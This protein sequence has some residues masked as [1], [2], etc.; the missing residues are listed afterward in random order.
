VNNT[1]SA[2]VGPELQRFRKAD[3]KQCA[4]CCIVESWGHVPSSSRDSNTRCNDAWRD[5]GYLFT[6]NFRLNFEEKRV[7]PN[8]TLGLNSSKA[9]ILTGKFSFF[10]SIHL[11]GLYEIR[12]VF[13]TL[14]QID[15]V[16][17]LTCCF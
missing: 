11:R 5:N 2:K 17:S 3:N 15:Q 14:Q 16:N 4:L 1:R 7:S 8:S 13:D 10:I 9:M 6:V 12:H